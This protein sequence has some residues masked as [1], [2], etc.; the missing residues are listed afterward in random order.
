MSTTDNLAL[1]LVETNQSQKEVTVNTAI[2]GIDAAMCEAE[3]VACEDGTNAVSAATMRATQ[4]LVLEDS[5]SPP[6]G[7]FYV[8][9]A[10]VKRLLFVRNATAENAVIVCADASSGAAEAELHA[11]NAAVLY[12]DGTQVH[13]INIDRAFVE[14]T[15]APSEY[16]SGS[17]RSLVRV[18]DTEDGLELVDPGDVV[19]AINPQSG[20]TYELASSDAGRLIT[21]DNASPITVTVPA[22][23]TAPLAVGTSILLAQIGDG[24]VLIDEADGV[25]VNTAQTLALRAKYSQA[26]LIKTATN[27]WL[28]AGDLEAA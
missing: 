27:V 8:E 28:L 9:L 26:S 17:A 13:R 20:V 25:T 24:Q 23:T 2:S 16:G 1:T 7:E 18:N 4:A 3:S 19:L 5:G 14:L 12:C 10:A 22:N 11:G 21:L 6:T 15:D